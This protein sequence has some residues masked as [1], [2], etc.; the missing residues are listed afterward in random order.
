MLNFIAFKCKNFVI[1]Q[2]FIP[3]LSKLKNKK[4]NSLDISFKLSNTR[5]EKSI[6]FSIYLKNFLSKSVNTLIPLS[7]L[8]SSFNVLAISDVNPQK[9]IIDETGNLTKSSISYIEK[10]LLKIK[11]SKQIEV[12]FVSVRNLPYGTNPQEYA[13]DLFQKWG[14]GDKDV[15]VVLVNKLSKA[16]IF[17]GD[18]INFI[19]YRYWLIALNGY[20]FVVVNKI[21]QK[22][23]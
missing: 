18:K 1:K 9:N 20:P 7:I 3:N 2:K 19:R 10:S 6:L 21:Y 11:E 17:Y 4:E 15:I 5:E 13:K 14:L 8:L 23:I 22:I 12:Y 16:G